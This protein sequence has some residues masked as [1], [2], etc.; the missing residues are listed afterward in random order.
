[1]LEARR[2]DENDDENVSARRIDEN[3]DENV[4]R[5]GDNSIANT[6]C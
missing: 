2:I 4:S 1:L 3:D 5:G 6:V